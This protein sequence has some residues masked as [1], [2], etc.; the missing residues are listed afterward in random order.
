MEVVSFVRGRNYVQS[1]QLWYREHLS[2]SEGMLKQDDAVAS[3]YLI[4]FVNYYA[5]TYI[6]DTMEKVKA[7]KRLY[8][9]NVK[10]AVKAVHQLLS[11]YHSFVFG[12]INKESHDDF[13]QLNSSME[14]NLAKQ[15]DSLHKA[16]TKALSEKGIV[17]TELPA[18][19]LISLMLCQFAAANTKNN[20][21]VNHDANPIM[22]PL[23]KYANL[24]PMDRHL[25]VICNAMRIPDV[26]KDLGI[27]SVFNK[28]QSLWYDYN[29]ISKSIP[30][31][32]FDDKEEAD[33]LKTSF[34]NAEKHKFN[35]INIKL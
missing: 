21:E 4:L 24:A 12:T 27:Y 7:D 30:D 9:Y 18:M 2:S 14:D 23:G 31:R 3:V 15:M 13:F 29:F 33:Y 25:Q 5:E 8:R 20:V 32:I 35:N 10:K 19:V 26:T 28:F 1:Y 6:F 16:V 34:N 22:K 11:E 17:E